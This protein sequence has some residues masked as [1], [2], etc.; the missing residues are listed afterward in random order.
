MEPRFL[1]NLFAR[2]LYGIA[3]LITYQSLDQIEKMK[4][5]RQLEK[6]HDGIKHNSLL[7]T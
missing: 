7:N 6:C 3:K 5:L 2:D 4:I 1:E